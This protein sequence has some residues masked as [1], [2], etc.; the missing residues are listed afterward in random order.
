MVTWLWIVAA[1]AMGERTPAP[2]ALTSVVRSVS[3]R[4][5]E[6][7]FVY[8]MS[9][10]RTPCYAVGG[11][12]LAVHNNSSIYPPL[13]AQINKLKT[14]LKASTAHYERIDGEIK[15][16]QKGLNRGEDALS[17]TDELWKKN[18]ALST[19]EEH[20]NWLKSEIVRLNKGIPKSTRWERITRPFW[21]DAS[22]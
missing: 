22:H 4:P 21:R 8:N 11:R 9:V 5:V 2:A 18:I 13:Y 17:L 7:V 12:S 15:T 6:G 19:L 14:A 10:A 1:L 20:M 3:R 16:L